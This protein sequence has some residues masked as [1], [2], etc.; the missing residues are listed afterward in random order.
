MVKMFGGEKMRNILIISFISL[1]LL[2]S[3]GV[4]FADEEPFTYITVEHEKVD[5]GYLLAIDLIVPEAITLKVNSNCLHGPIVA[6]ISSLK[7]ELYSS[8]EIS[9]DRIFIKTSYTRSFVSM[10]RPVMI[11][12]TAFGSQDITIDFKVKTSV[13]RDIHGA[14]T[15]K[16]T[17][18]LMPPV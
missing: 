10:S 8:D 14:Y 15:G 12:E 13:Y 11:S 5:L 1:L 9:K 18:T 4:S 3:G 7:H 2:C 17:F 16:L 6:S